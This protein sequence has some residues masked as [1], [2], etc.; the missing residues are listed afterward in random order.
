MS[1]ATA[2]LVP[3]TR[4][5]RTRLR[6]PQSCHWAREVRTVACRNAPELKTSCELAQ[7]GSLAGRGRRARSDHPAPPRPYL[8]R[9]VLLGNF[10]RVLLS[11]GRLRLIGHLLSA[12]SCFRMNS[13]SSLLSRRNDR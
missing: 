11:P 4:R 5:E 10:D 12:T 6:P 1:P 9:Q 13:S 7:P 3:I 8:V 2:G